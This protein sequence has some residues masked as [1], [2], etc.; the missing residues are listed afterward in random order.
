MKVRKQS[1]E[2]LTSLCSHTEIPICR[3]LSLALDIPEIFY[4]SDIDFLEALSEYEGTLDFN[5]VS[6]EDDE[7]EED[8]I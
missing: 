1:L 3:V 4:T 8:T 6:Y 7:D 5:N 2:L